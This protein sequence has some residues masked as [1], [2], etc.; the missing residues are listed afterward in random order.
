MDRALRGNRLTKQRGMERQGT[1][2]IILPKKKPKNGPPNIYE[3]VKKVIKKVITS[4]RG[5]KNKRKG[6]EV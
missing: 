2:P 4:G 3:D 5:S 6:W 1:S